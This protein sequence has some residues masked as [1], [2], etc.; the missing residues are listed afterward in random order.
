MGVTPVAL[1]NHA[2]DQRSSS[3][4]P[5]HDCTNIND[6]DDVR[7]FMN[8]TYSIEVLR[9]YGICVDTPVLVSKLEHRAGVGQQL[10]GVG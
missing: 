1:A 7:S 6:L 9:R 4:K 10:G 5:L 2:A 8:K 3:S